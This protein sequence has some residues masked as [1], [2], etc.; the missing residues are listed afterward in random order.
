[1]RRL[2]VSAAAALVLLLGACGDGPSGPVDEVVVTR[3]SGNNQTRVTGTYLADPLTVLLTTADGQPAASRRV[4]FEV[5]EGVAALALESAL[6][7]ASGMAA[8]RALLGPEP[9]TVVVTATAFPS[10]RQAVFQATAVAADS[11]PANDADAAGDGGREP[12]AS[13]ALTLDGSG[14]YLVVR[15][16]PSLYGHTRQTVEL[17]FRLDRFGE[18]NSFGW[19]QLLSNDEY[20]LAVRAGDRRVV[21]CCYNA[22]WTLTGGTAI[23]TGRWYHVAF[24]RDQSAQRLYLDGQLDAAG[25]VSIVEPSLDLWIGNDPSPSTRP[26]AGQ[27]DEVRVWSRALSEAE[28]RES[29]A[30]DLSGQEEN[31]EGCWSFDELAGEGTV[32]DASSNGNDGTLVGDAHTAEAE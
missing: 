10:G 16:D 18:G 13:R 11:L 28:I 19:S 5:V 30:A 2:A 20:E 22:P 26:F 9:G 31:L 6:S 25:T 21:A 29:M 27:I 8:T 23:V 12:A 15:R 4:D 17:W 14:D 1:M 3:V 24:V 7:N 32:H